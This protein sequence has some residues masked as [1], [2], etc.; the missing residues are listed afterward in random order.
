MAVRTIVLSRHIADFLGS[1]RMET[2]PTSIEVLL[3]PTIGQSDEPSV[4]RGSLSPTTQHHCTHVLVYTAPGCPR[5]S[6]IHPLLNFSDR[7]DTDELTPYSVPYLSFV[8]SAVECF[9]ALFYFHSTTDDYLNL[10][11]TWYERITI[12][13]TNTGE[14]LALNTSLFRPSWAE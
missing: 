2:A 9:I 11:V 14:N 12:K 6:P 13:E 10:K 8:S 3:R 7:A 5:R 4:I 1:R